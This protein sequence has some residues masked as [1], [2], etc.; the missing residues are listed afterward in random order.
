MFFWLGESFFILFFC[1][2][3]FL[4]NFLL[5][6]KIICFSLNFSVLPNNFS[7]KLTGRVQENLLVQ[8]REGDRLDL[9]IKRNL[10]SSCTP[11]W[12]APKPIIHWILNQL[13]VLIYNPFWESF[14]R[15]FIIS[16]DEDDSIVLK[17][18][19][20]IITCSRA[21]SRR[22]HGCKVALSNEKTKTYK[23]QWHGVQTNRCG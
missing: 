15:T 4:I 13:A 23:I 19:S 5:K 11:K 21:V 9:K 1:I 6:I 18:I 17:R 2:H 3:I 12:W 22:K 7:D 20:K 14:Y 10:I 16:F 8:V